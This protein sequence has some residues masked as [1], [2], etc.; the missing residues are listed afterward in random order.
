M[1]LEPRPAA[2]ELT[3]GLMPTQFLICAQELRMGCIQKP[4][5]TK[6]TVGHGH[7]WSTKGKCDAD[8]LHCVFIG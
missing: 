6:T 4:I 7:Y 1:A 5:L 8:R 2:C 3:T